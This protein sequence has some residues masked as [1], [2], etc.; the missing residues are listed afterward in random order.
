MILYKKSHNYDEITEA[1]RIVK[2][3]IIDKRLIL[4]GGMAI[5]F[6]LKLNGDSIYTEGQLPDYDF[7]SPTHIEHAYELSQI[8]CKK[9]FTNVSCIQA[10]HLTTMKV[11]VNFEVVADITYCPSSIFKKI[12]YLKYADIK[13]VHPHYQMIDQHNAI[14]IPFE[15]PGREV[16]FHRWKK[17]MIRYDKLYKYYPVVITKENLPPNKNNIIGGYTRTAEREL[18]AKTLE[19]ELEEIE[20]KFSDIKDGCICGWGGIDY[21]IK[22]DNI[23]L[24]IPKDEF[25]S[26][27]SYDYKSFVKN[28]NLTIDEHY[29]EYFGQIPRYV[30]C[31]SNI[32]GRSFQIFDVRGILLSANQ[33][34]KKYNVYICNI[35]W[36]MSYLMNRIFRQDNK[37]IVFTAEERYLFCRDLVKQGEVP[38]ILVYGTE[39]YT[40]A[41]VNMI[42]TNKEK[43]YNIKGTRLQPYNVYPKH[44]DCVTD[45]EFDIESSQYFMIDGRRLDSFLEMTLNPYPDYP[46]VKV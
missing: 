13:L 10:L 31:E 24:K 12:P 23:V 9:K 11:R 2:Q 29:S 19:M 33:I 3:F 16:I 21:K 7:Y 45:K 44:P 28:N 37:K 39:N 22:K 6:A 42:K 5:D 34:S 1:L 20:V 41:Y 46:P 8:L 4:V 32:K 36:C 25:I 27:A 43:I 35:Q 26:I 14:S 15:N 30:T 18:M 38:D 17:D 40:P